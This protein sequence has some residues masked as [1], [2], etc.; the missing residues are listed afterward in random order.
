MN[1]ARLSR[2]VFAILAM[3]SIAM[4]VYASIVP[5]HY[6]PL[7]SPMPLN[8]LKK[9]PGCIWRLIVGRTGW[10]MPWLLSHRRFWSWLRWLEAEPAG[11][12]MAVSSFGRGGDGGYRCGD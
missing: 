1:S 4:L 6:Q 9:H 5:L 8:A 10:R 7:R 2:L 11:L 3:G 12:D